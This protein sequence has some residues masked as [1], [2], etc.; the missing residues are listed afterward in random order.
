MST[1][2]KR[3]LGINGLDSILGGGVPGGS[4]ILVTG[5]SGSGKTIFGAKFLYEGALR[6]GEKGIYISFNESKEKFYNYMMKLGM[7]FHDLERRGLIHYEEMLEYRSVN[8][9]V[10]RI[11]N[12]LS[13]FGYSRITIDSLTSLKM[14]GDERTVKES[15]RT[16]LTNLAKSRDSITLLIANCRSPNELTSLIDLSLID[17]IIHLD[18]VEY[19]DFMIRKLK[20]IKFRGVDIV[21]QESL[22]FDITPNKVIRL[23]VPIRIEEIPPLSEELYTFDNDRINNLLGGGIRK[24]AQVAVVSNIPKIGFIFSLCLAKSLAMKYG[25][26]LLVRTYTLSPNEVDILLSKCY[27]LESVI[28][29]EDVRRRPKKYIKHIMSHSLTSKDLFTISSE[30]RAMDLKLREDFLVADSFELI[31]AKFTDVAREHVNNI[32]LRKKLGITAFY[33]YHKSTYI[34]HPELFNIYD[35]IL[36]LEAQ[37]YFGRAC[38]K[39]SATNFARLRPPSE[40]MLCYDILKDSYILM[41]K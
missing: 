35:T 37:T 6:Y 7:D 30:N 13:K 34:E 5:E 22:I 8:E 36:L 32:W 28:L 3:L 11:S 40:S 38:L 12:I 15:I 33:N 41:H 20:I 24:G 31:P 14:L 16:L 25:G 29:N 4:I 19:H 21:P 23:H 26:R 17:G 18:V 10:N 9:I 27:V 39:I 2:E 1:R